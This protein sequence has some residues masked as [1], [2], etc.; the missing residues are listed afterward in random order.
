MTHVLSHVVP[1]WPSNSCRGSLSPY[2]FPGVV[3]RR[4]SALEVVAYRVAVE[5]VTNLAARH[6]GVAAALVTFTSRPDMR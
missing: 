2:T 5:A 6:S 4:L 3:L 1:R